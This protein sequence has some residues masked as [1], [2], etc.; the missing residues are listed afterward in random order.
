[1][2]LVPCTR[3]WDKLHGT[4]WMRWADIVFVGGSED[5]LL[6]QVPCTGTKS[7]DG[8][9]YN[10]CVPM[11]RRNGPTEAV[12]PVTQIAFFT[13]CGKRSVES[14][15]EVTIVQLTLHQPPTWPTKPCSCQRSTG[16]I[17]RV[18]LGCAA[19]ALAYTT[20]LILP[21]CPPNT[22]TLVD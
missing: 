6:Y 12:L 15:I 17:R 19:H 3:Q 18:L 1:M 21:T 13:C 7:G 9:C 14:D 22:S 5:A 4:N 20:Y 10:L 8:Y 11:M 2:N 16:H